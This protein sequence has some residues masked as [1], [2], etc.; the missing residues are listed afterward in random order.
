MSIIITQSKD[1]IIED[2]LEDIFFDTEELE[3]LKHEIKQVALG[4]LDAL[5]LKKTILK[6]RMRFKEEIIKDFLPYYKEQVNRS[7]LQTSELHQKLKEREDLLETI[8]LKINTLHQKLQEKKTPENISELAEVNSLLKDKNPQKDPPTPNNMV[9]VDLNNILN[10]DRD[11]NENLKVEN[12]L[13]LYNSVLDL[14][15]EPH[16]VADA[17]M[18]H[19]VNS[20]DQYEDLVDRKIINQAAAGTKADGWVLK[21]AKRWHCKFLSND[22]FREYRDEFGR[23][24]IADHRITCIFVNGTFIIQESNNYQE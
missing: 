23:E 11:E 13:N 4:T 5:S 1:T 20:K 12:V 18:R 6:C 17:N 22:L 16:L 24:W 9:V 2:L 14:G 7:S 8:A 10:L 3:L 21:I 19:H 15:Y